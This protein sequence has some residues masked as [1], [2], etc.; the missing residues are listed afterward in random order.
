MAYMHLCLRIINYNTS[1]KL[2]AWS[3]PIPFTGNVSFTQCSHNLEIAMQPLCFMDIS[4]KTITPENIQI[5]IKVFKIILFVKFRG[6]P[7]YYCM[8]IINPV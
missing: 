2:T 8:T 4:T 6:G 5:A 1:Y 3:Y 7:L